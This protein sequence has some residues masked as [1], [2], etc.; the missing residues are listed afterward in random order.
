LPACL[1]DAHLFR[2]PTAP[3]QQM[4]EEVLRQ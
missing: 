1:T 3:E 2:E 4:P